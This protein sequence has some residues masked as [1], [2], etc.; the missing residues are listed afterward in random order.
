[1]R[2]LQF[3]LRQSWDQVDQTVLIRW[4]PEIRQDL[5]WWLNRAL[6]E[7][8]ILLAQVSPQLDLWSDAS[9]V[10]WGAHLGEEVTSGL[11]SREEVALSINARELLA[12]ERA[13]LFFAP[14]ISNCTV[15][16]FADN[17]TAIAYL[18]N[19]GSTRSRLLNSISQRILR[20]AESLHSGFP[21]QTQSDRRVGV[22]FKS[23]GFSRSAKEVAG[24]HR[25]VR[26]LVKSPN[27]AH[28]FLRSTIRTLWA[29]MLCS[30]IGM[31]GRRMPFLLGLSYR[32]F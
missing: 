10:S 7:Q 31:G 30:R 16:M 2:S 9:D 17:S 28:I 18:R 22:D 4:T 23:R 26:N 24:V 29:R 32:Q 8:G 6:L 5:E 21:V 1:M 12:V 14:Q 3:V 20:W 15:A 11:W 27:V 13:L 25:P 19:H